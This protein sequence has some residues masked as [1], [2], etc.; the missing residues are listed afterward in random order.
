MKRITFLLPI[1]CILFACNDKKGSNIPK[2]TFQGFIPDTP[3][4]VKSWYNQNPNPLPDYMEFD[5]VIAFEDGDGDLAS[6]DKDTLRVEVKYS[7]TNFKDTLNDFIIPF[8]K[9]LGDD[10]PYNG[11]LYLKFK[12]CEC[13]QNADNS[14]IDTVRFRIKVKDRAGNESNEIIT[15]PVY[16]T[17]CN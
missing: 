15:E 16:I 4:Y 8:Q 3:V 1:L 5:A 9:D 11:K 2:I 12:A 17:N 7:K 10:M 14:F 13:Y 6:K